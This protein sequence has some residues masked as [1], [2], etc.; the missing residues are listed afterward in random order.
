MNWTQGGSRQVIVKMSLWRND[1]I[2]VL[3]GLRKV[4]Y[5]SASLQQA[6]VQQK[7][8]NSSLQPLVEQG[9]D[10]LRS[11]SKNITPAQLS[12]SEMSF[13]TWNQFHYNF[14]LNLHFSFLCDWTVK[15]IAP[16]LHGK[17]PLRLATEL[18]TVIAVNVSILTFVLENQYSIHLSFP[19]LK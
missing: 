12:V 2:G 10:V 19:C 5:A 13:L 18:E 11:I 7:W 6:E 16:T 9:S 8:K 14:L 4:V 17:K 3:N 15:I 1:I